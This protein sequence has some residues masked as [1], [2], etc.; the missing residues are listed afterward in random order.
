MKTD[1]LFSSP[2]IRFS[3]LQKESILAWGKDLG[4]R[5]VPSLYKLEKFQG[6]ALEAVGDPTVKIQA[7]LGNIFYMNSVRHAL[8]RVSSSHLV[9]HSMYSLIEVSY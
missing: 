6:E 2:S 4:A 1:I 8:A 9:W 3:R 5:D 7:A